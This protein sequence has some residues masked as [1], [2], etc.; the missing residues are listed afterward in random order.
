VERGLGIEAEKQRRH[1]FAL[2][3]KNQKDIKRVFELVN[4]ESPFLTR[5]SKTKV[6]GHKKNG[7]Q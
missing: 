3:V 4:K 7:F 1:S 5:R 6:L 2:I